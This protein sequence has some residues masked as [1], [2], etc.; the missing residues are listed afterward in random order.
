MIPRLALAL[1]ICNK[2]GAVTNNKNPPEVG[3]PPRSGGKFLR[4]YNAP[5]GKSAKN[6]LGGVNVIS[7]VH[8]LRFARTTKTKIMFQP[9]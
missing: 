5:D 2:I 7:P 6:R 3:S 9:K 1:N 4:Y 8:I